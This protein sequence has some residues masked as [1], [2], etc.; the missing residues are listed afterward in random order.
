[1][2][3]AAMRVAETG[4]GRVG[5]MSTAMTLDELYD[6][7][8]SNSVHLSDAMMQYIAVPVSPL[9]WYWDDQYRELK[10]NCKII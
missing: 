2:V 4:V 7:G 9:I 6:D 8:D 10:K 3:A 1:M 5:G